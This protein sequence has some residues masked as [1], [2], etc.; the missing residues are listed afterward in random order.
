MSFF[1]TCKPTGPPL[2]KVTICLTEGNIKKSLPGVQF[3]I[4]ECDP[5]Y[6]CEPYGSS[7]DEAAFG[8][9]FLS[10]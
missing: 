4:I 5:D 2:H 1:R 6:F 10:F 3:I 8:Y 7:G 9:V